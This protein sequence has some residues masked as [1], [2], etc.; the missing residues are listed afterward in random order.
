MPTRRQVVAAVDTRLREI[1]NLQVYLRRVGYVLGEDVDRPPAKISPTD[2][3][4]RPY[5]TQHPSVGSPLEERLGGHQN[6]LLWS[7]QITCVVGDETALEPLVDAV[8]ARLD[9]WRPFDGLGRLRVPV[10]FDPGPSRRDDDESPS[11][12]W[13]PLQY[14]LA[15]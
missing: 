2:Q 13:V 4:V 10:G 1:P 14:Q 3:R 8:T 11:R 5:V 9:M 7:A 15:L 12:Y 6:G